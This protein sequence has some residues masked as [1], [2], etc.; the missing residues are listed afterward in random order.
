M[1]LFKR[2]NYAQLAKYLRKLY[3]NCDQHLYLH[4]EYV[5]KD[6]IKQG[7]YFDQEIFVSE[8]SEEMFKNDLKKEAKRLEVTFEELWETHEEDVDDFIS[9]Y[10]KYLFTIQTLD[11]VMVNNHMGLG[12]TPY[13]QVK[14]WE[15]LFI[16]QRF[17]QLTDKDIFFAIEYFLHEVMDIFT[18][19][20][21]RYNGKHVQVELEKILPSYKNAREDLKAKAYWKEKKYYGVW[22]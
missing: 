3:W 7:A 10:D 19:F 17:G 13:Y 8:Y 6:S 5:E 14:D 18:L 2:N 12:C 22:I 20:N 9:Y 21:I 1:N 15:R 16:V 4:S 11:N